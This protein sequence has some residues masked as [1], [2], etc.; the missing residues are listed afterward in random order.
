[1]QFLAW[2]EAHGLAR[3]DAYFGTGAGIAADASLASADAENAKASQFDAFAVGESLLQA[4]ENCVYSSLCLG[5][6]QARAL[7]HMMDDVLLNQ[8]GTS[9]AELN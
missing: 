3:R 6:G 8:S 9:L 4:L 1:V 5:A 2:L 7:N